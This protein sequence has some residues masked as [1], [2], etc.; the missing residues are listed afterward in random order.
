MAVGTNLR[1][2]GIIQELVPA[3][4]G[5]M[6]AA[7]FRDTLKYAAAGGSFE[8][9]T[10]DVEARAR[11]ILADAGHDPQRPGFMPTPVADGS[12]VAVAHEILRWI[13][14]ARAA[15]AKQDAQTA[16]HAGVQ[17][18]WLVREH[19]LKV[20]WEKPALRGQAFIEGPRAERRDALARLIDDAFRKLG[21][22]AIFKAIL[23]HLRTKTAVVHEV[24]DQ[25]GA[26]YWKTRDGRE[27]E[28]SFKSLRNRI[29]ERRKRVNQP[30]KPK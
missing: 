2:T 6:S 5:D 16:A 4:S 22:D 10:R 24:D 17:I 9:W 8:G 30:D 3:L 18:G 13:R 15:I 28:T 25:E 23:D 11:K 26:I 29:A 14:I 7:D 20:D 19:D 1:G 27:R 21:H 12:P